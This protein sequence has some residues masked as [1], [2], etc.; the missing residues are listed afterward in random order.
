[1]KNSVDKRFF[2]TFLKMY[3]TMDIAMDAESFF[4]KYSEQLLLEPEHSQSAEN[5]GSRLMFKS[6]NGWIMFQTFAFC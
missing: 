1:M 2:P 6:F 3:S 5:C 4:L